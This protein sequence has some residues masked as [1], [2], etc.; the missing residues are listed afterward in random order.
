MD[1]LFQFITNHPFLV[2]S[3]AILLI[4][5][6]RLQSNRSG[7]NV[8]AQELVNLVN[9]EGAV[10]LDVRDAQEF[11]QGHIVDAVNMPHTAVEAHL[12]ELNKYKEKPVIVVCKAGQNAGV[13]GTAL[14]KAGF[15]KVSRLAGGMGEWRNQNLPVVKGRNR[16]KGKGKGK[17]QQ[18]TNADEE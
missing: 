2:S 14:H 6:L 13:V 16:S 17:A 7:R 18:E 4:L 11:S 9:R 3:F 10:V 1:K 15:Q 12:S 5:L 8:S